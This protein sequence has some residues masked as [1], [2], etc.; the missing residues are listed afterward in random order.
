MRPAQDIYR[1]PCRQAEALRYRRWTAVRGLLWK[2]CSGRGGTCSTGGF[3]SAVFVSA[4]SAFL[5]FGLDR[6]RPV[7]ELQKHGER[8]YH[9]FEI[10]RSK[11]FR[12]VTRSTNITTCAEERTEIRYVIVLAEKRPRHSEYS[13]CQCHDDHVLMGTGD[14]FG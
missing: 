7:V 12:K 3:S 8:N 4:S 14:Q 2:A 9:E 6:L 1:L 10:D 13:V 11:Q 5:Y